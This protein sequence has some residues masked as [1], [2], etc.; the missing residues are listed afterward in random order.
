MRARNGAYTALAVVA[1]L[2]VG[3]ILVQ[4]FLAG[5]GVFGTNGFVT[6]REFGYMIGWLT[7]VMVVIAV[8]GRLGRTLIGL[9]VLTLVQM[10]LQSVLILFRD[11]QPAVAALHPVNGVLLLIVTI[12]IGRLA[13]AGRTAQARAAAADLAVVPPAPAE[14]PS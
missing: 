13:W 10:A 5:I 11:D 7:L 4:I 8:A 12:T 9:S 2:F 6:H 3:C 1:W 14:S